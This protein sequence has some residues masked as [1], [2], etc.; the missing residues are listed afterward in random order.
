MK[1]LVTVACL[2]SATAFHQPSRPAPALLLRESAAGA[3]A[4]APA[5]AADPRLTISDVPGMI[6]LD[7]ITLARQGTALDALGASP[8]P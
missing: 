2:M 6:Q 3:D 1:L 4:A 8:A 5:E 7:D